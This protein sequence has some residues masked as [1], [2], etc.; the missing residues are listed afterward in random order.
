GG[1]LFLCTNYVA[2][3]AKQNNIHTMLTDEGLYGDICVSIDDDDL[4][5]VIPNHI[6]TSIEQNHLK[7]IQ[8][9]F[10]VSYTLGEMPLDNG[11]FRWTDFYPEVA[12]DPSSDY[13]Q[14]PDIM[15]K[16]N[17]IATKQAKDSY[18]LKV[19]VY[20]YGN[21][22]FHDLSDYILDGEIHPESMMQENKIVL[23][24]LMDG[25]GYYDGIAIKPGDHIT[26]KVPKSEFI[27]SEPDL[28]KFQ[29]GEECYIEK[30]FVVAALVSRCVGENDALIGSGTDVVSVIMPQQMMEQHFSIRDYNQIT[31]KME[32]VDSSEKI[33]QE[34]RSYLKGLSSCVIHDYR[35]GIKKKNQIL[36]QKVYFF[37]G[38]SIILFLI[39]LL[40][41]V[42]SM[43][44]LIWTR[45]YEFGV[46][47]AMGI[48]DAGFRSMLVRQGAMYG[49]ISSIV[50]L[51]V[52]LLCQGV[53]AGIMQ[54][55]IRYIIVSRGISLV[56]CI[57]MAL[58]NSVVCILA[59]V[60]CGQE[61]LREYVVDEIRRYD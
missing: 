17:G 6:V 37:Y 27:H 10:P 57:G 20:G 14:D 50:M 22:Q 41:A 51:I 38:I 46:L 39:S 30:D 18:R 44:H 26:L 45:R 11:I 58:W 32:E 7:G 33:V 35:G 4:G 28:L 56:S 15:E 12:E 21:E 16:Y 9:I 54:H 52:T 53:L 47:R 61:L 3:N 31:I 8:K 1:V 5:K 24:T 13:A 29:A 48:T 42:N 60:C 19:N 25:G 36:M 43:K 34:I 40:H 49:M 23:K 2:D 55:V 59:M